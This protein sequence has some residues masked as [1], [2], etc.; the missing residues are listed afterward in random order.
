VLGAAL[1]VLAAPSPLQ[2]TLRLISFDAYQSMAP[3]VSASDPVVIVA[4]DETSVARHGQ[5]PW[6]RARVGRLVT[7][8]AQGDPAA[9][10][11]AMVMAEPDR[12]AALLAGIDD[13]LTA[14][15]RALEG[16]DAALARSIRNQPVVLGVIGLD[17]PAPAGAPPLRRA[18][19]L[20]HGPDPVPAVRRFEGALGAIDEI[21]AAAAGHG[22]VSADP[23]RGVLRRL[24]LVAA[25]GQALVPGLG[26]EMLRVASG[27][28]VLTVR[29]GVR[30]VQSVE[31]GDLAISTEE[32][33][34]VWIP[35]GLHRPARFVSAAEVLE[36]RVPPTRFT[37]KLVLI[38]ATALGL[39][40]YQTTPMAE[41]MAGVEVH[42]QLLEAI[43]DGSLLRRP[44]W[45]P[46]AE[47]TALAAGGLLLVVAVSVLPVRRSLLLGVGLAGAVAGLG[48]LGYRT[49][50]VLLDA[51]SPLLGL[52]VVYTAMLGATLTETRSQRRALRRQ[53]LQ[54][55]EAAAR[56]AGELEAA[57]RIQIG[58]LPDAATAFPGEHRFA[59]HACLDPAREVGGD[60]YDFFL[61]DDRHLFF[62]IG[63]V[64]GKG[65]P[66]SLFMALSKSLCKSA[67]L[68]QGAEVARAMREANT[69][70]S[71]D[72]RESVFVTVVAGVLDAETGTLEY[73]TAGH[74]SPYLLPGPGRPLS[75]LQAG[76]G[77]PLCVVDGFAYQPS[78]VGLRPGDTLCLVTDG[79][80]EAMDERG[81]LYGRERL[82][83][84]LAGL[85][86][87]T[88]LAEV[89]EA[90]QRDVTRFTAGTD[91]ADDVA[92][93]AVRWLGPTAPVL[94]DHPTREA[95]VHAEVAPPVSGC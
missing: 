33:G 42:A 25:V 51:A 47:A 55:R 52:G 92:I 5:W 50:R 84:L 69:E 14:R 38:G 9:I 58:I 41:R 62:A 76:T 31:I 35:F 57:R 63:D 30:G 6:P 40:D 16:Q 48:F 13:D 54:E 94:R 81:E 27:R 39:S 18:P 66:G 29:A 19:I 59:L 86:P 11:L 32:D 15:L 28:P 22:L 82:E 7:L 44:G 10:G 2:R 45:A 85:G 17:E 12:L 24:P 80:V 64:S 67:A 74:D 46:W 23:E 61:L 34:T 36:G 70:I 1:V 78:T 91:A 56:L 65:L 77:P 72:N 21:A 53:L 95:R 71:R 73:C 79:V 68:R 83:T 26:I 88:G 89:A 20:V 90:V 93:L 3:R 43:F 87:G 8:V 60:F 4:I 49:H 75:Q 37:R